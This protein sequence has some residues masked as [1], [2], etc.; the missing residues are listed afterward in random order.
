[1]SKLLALKSNKN[2]PS[3]YE[4]NTVTIVM[5]INFSL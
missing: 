5:V 1:M 3:T 2:T 4:L